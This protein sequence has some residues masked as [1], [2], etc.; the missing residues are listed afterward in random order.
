MSHDA[1]L[2]TAEFAALPSS[3]GWPAVIPAA[4]AAVTSDER[5]AIISHAPQREHCEFADVTPL[6]LRG[7]AAEPPVCS[8]LSSVLPVQLATMNH[9]IATVRDSRQ[10]PHPKQLGVGV[11][12]TRGVATEW[13]RAPTVRGM[14]KRTLGCG[15]RPA[16]RLMPWPAP[17]DGERCS[18]L[19]RQR[20]RPA[21]A[22][23]AESASSPQR[24]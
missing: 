2:L 7:C 3:K 17:G 9:A 10:P 13:P 8:A 22:A 18:E 15:G 23:E 24:N 21:V 11:S 20:K 19:I 4:T 5:P 1:V 14:A 6:C 12:I 16:P